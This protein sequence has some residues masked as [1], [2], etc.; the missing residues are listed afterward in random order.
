MKKSILFVAAIAT[1]SL[2][3]AQLQIIGDCTD[4]SGNCL[5]YVDEQVIIANKEKDK[6]FKYSP[7]VDMKNGALECG[8]ILTTMVNIGNCVE[9]NT[10]IFLLDDGSKVMLKSWNKFNCDGDAW[11]NISKDEMNLLR[12]HKVV[13]AQMQNGY[14]YESFQSDV[15]V[16]DQDY[17]IRF[18]AD[19]DANKFTPVK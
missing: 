6:G 4:L 12:E 17:F 14:S 3:N 15:P 2:L 5:Y 16:S 19:V 1:S 8:G 11:F 9:N 18:F 7:S 10:L 13:K